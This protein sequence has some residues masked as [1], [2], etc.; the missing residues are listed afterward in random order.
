MVV[1]VPEGGPKVTV[2]IDRSQLAL[3]GVSTEHCMDCGDGFNANQCRRADA[4]MT[5][6]L[7]ARH[8]LDAIED[9]AD[10][11]AASTADIGQE[12]G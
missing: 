8:R 2:E 10:K 11:A 3:L 9:A 6:L 5:T 12:T 1:E 7:D 4:V